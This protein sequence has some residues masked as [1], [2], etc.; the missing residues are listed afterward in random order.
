MTLVTKARRTTVIFST[1]LRRRLR[2]FYTVTAVH[3]RLSFPRNC[4]FVCLCDRMM[5][6]FPTCP[7]LSSPKARQAFWLSNWT[8]DGVDNEPRREG[9]KKTILVSLFFFLFVWFKGKDLFPWYV[10]YIF[11]FSLFGE[12]FPA[13]FP[14]RNSSSF[15]SPL[16][17]P[18]GGRRIPPSLQQFL[19][20]TCEHKSSVVA[21]PL[22]ETDVSLPTSLFTTP[23][24]RFSF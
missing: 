9:E 14:W 12:I 7:H 21:S 23:S 10:G 6:R 4:C 18:S 8:L 3:I 17:R 15:W 19:V 20:E 5:I 16:L 2:R 1:T 13:V 11:S 22:L 24:F